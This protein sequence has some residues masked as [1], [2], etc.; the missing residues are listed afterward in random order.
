MARPL[1]QPPPTSAPT[2]ARQEVCEGGRYGVYA[3]NRIAD[4]C[5]SLYA[6]HYLNRHG[7]KLEC[8]K[9]VDMSD[10]HGH[11]DPGTPEVIG[12]SSPLPVPCADNSRACPAYKS[13]RT[14]ISVSHRMLGVYNGPIASSVKRS[15]SRH[16][17]SHDIRV[18]Y[19]A[20]DYLSRFTVFSP[21]L[22]HSR[23]HPGPS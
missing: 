15:P 8:R 1:P 20:I 3:C 5:V 6:L 9:L 19:A 2:H 7:G 18:V 16:G 23:K 17:Y 4:F 10:R 12:E 21:Q 14:F 22:K 13:Q 11:A